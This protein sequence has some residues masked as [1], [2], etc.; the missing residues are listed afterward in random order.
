MDAGFIL[1]AAEDIDSRD[2]GGGLY[3]PR[4]GRKFGLLACSRRGTLSWE[5]LLMFMF[6]Y[7][8]VLYILEI[9]T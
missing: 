7:H 8:S 5:H 2:D 6:H 9:S 3:N 4:R 1:E